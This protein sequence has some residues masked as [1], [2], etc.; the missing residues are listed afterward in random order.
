[1]ARRRSWGYDDSGLGDIAALG[2]GVITGLDAGAS[3]AERFHRFL[4]YEDAKKNANE[5]RRL[6]RALSAI[7]AVHKAPEL[8]DQYRAV[9]GSDFPDVSNITDQATRARTALSR[10]ATS[11]DPN[12]L[13]PES[14]NPYLAH[15]LQ[16][17][18]RLSKLVQETA[19]RRALADEQKDFQGRVA[20]L[21]AKGLSPAEAQRRAM[22]DGSYLHL[23]K[24]WGF[25]FRDA[26]GAPVSADKELERDDLK[27]AGEALP[28]NMRSFASPGGLKLLPH[29]PSVQGEIARARGLG[30]AVG[31]A[32]APYMPLGLAE[33]I[34]TANGRFDNALPERS[35][36]RLPLTGAF[37][38]ARRGEPPPVAVGPGPVPA[39]LP[40]RPRT[41][42]DAQAETERRK[43]EARETPHKL[44]TDAARLDLQRRGVVARERSVDISGQEFERR[45]QRDADMKAQLGAT[46]K[47]L[48]AQAVDIARTTFP[49][50]PVKQRAF[51]EFLQGRVR[52]IGTLAAAKDAEREGGIEAVI[53]REVQRLKGDVT[54]AIP[55]AD[56]A[57]SAATWWNP[58]TWFGGSTSARALPPRTAAP[59]SAPQSAAPIADPK[60]LRAATDALVNA[61]FPGRSYLDLTPEEKAQ[62]AARLNAGAR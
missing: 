50:D 39:F 2:Q 10:F 6:G 46:I 15:Y 38:N 30:R 47:T 40:G 48:E 55:E 5:D 27:T 52:G 8:A 11:R 14:G 58:A 29:V 31:E 34:D 53:A 59:P 54:Q 3:N 23:P 1:M 42:G 17:D 18:P 24:A 45:R 49:H 21:T 4:Q 32:Q 60:A 28:E 62:V 13:T 61:L 56:Q 9:M 22:T 20:D 41:V 7:T 35:G 51:T 16:A 57:L 25:R 36:D 26:V 44:E 43:A 19:D 12:D 37:G 33:I